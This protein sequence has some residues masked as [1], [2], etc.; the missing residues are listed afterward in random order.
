MRSLRGM[1]GSHGLDAKVAKPVRARMN[2]LTRNGRW[3]HDERVL[4]QG[5]PI[6]AGRIEYARRPR[7]G[8]NA[9]IDARRSLR[10]GRSVTVPAVRFQAAITREDSGYV[11][12]CLEVDVASQGETPEVAL[13]NLKE[14]LE[15]YFAGEPHPVV[16]PAQ[17]HTVEIA[18]P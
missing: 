2:Y 8:S 6:A 13:M 11:A 9:H 4:T 16:V 14:A 10:D 5:L 18:L 3:L 1:I 15:L 17:V 12:Q 7:P